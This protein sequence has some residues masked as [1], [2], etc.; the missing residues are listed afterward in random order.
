MF[1]FPI[2]LISSVFSSHS[3][4]PFVFCSSGPAEPGAWLS[5]LARPWRWTGSWLNRMAWRRRSSRRFHWSS[6]PAAPQCPSS[7][8]PTPN[9]AAAGR[10][11]ASPRPGPSPQQS[12]VSS[13]HRWS[14]WETVP[15]RPPHYYLKTPGVWSSFWR[16]LPGGCG[17]FSCS[18]LA[19][20]EDFC[21]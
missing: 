4:D 2:L 7:L 5:S 18:S 11:T 14:S 6:R 10:R 19:V 16:A 9:W 15:D 12:F 8:H 1:L 3:I 21:P 20:H 13:W 17:P